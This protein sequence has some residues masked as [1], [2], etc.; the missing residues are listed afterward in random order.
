MSLFYLGREQSREE[1]VEDYH[2][3]QGISVLKKHDTLLITGKLGSAVTSTAESI[4]K[5]FIQSGSEWK[6]RIHENHQVP[7][8]FYSYTVYFVYCCFGL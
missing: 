8:Y 5:E 3:E 1:V 6:F 4:M 2:V 7:V